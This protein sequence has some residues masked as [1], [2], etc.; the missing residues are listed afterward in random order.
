MQYGEIEV[1][2]I[3]IDECSEKNRERI[4]LPEIWHSV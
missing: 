1:I 4:T 3:E 2:D